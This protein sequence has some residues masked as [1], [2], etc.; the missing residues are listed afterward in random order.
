L[1]IKLFPFESAL[2]DS[3]M[4]LREG[5]VQH[6]LTGGVD[7]ITDHS[8]AIL[9]R[10]GLYKQAP[11]RNTALLQSATKGTIAGEGA[12]FFTLGT[13]MTAH[14]VARL[15]GVSTLYRP[16]DIPEITGAL[17]VFLS[18]HACG[19]EDIDLLICG[20]NGNADEDGV[21]EA[22]TQA[23]F[24]Q[25]AVA[26]FKHLSGEYPT[27]AAFATWMAARILQLQ[28]LSP[29]VLI[30]GTA[31]AKIRK[32]LICNGYQGTHYSFILLAHPN[33]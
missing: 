15:T 24:P 32:I 10:F 19:P 20:R 21:Y 30:S 25:T 23:L 3:I 13:E 4:M 18:S 5:A 9:S 26:G 22:I 11:I 7:E 31:P 12:A 2:L 27:A 8:H 1:Y 29:G 14:T 28:E 6:I 33:I 17:Q 16:A